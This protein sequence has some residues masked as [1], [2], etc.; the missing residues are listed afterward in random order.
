MNRA[1]GNVSLG[2]ND[3]GHALRRL[4]NEFVVRTAHAL[5]NEAFALEAANDVGAVGEHLCLE[6]IQ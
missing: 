4:V 6:P 5:E 3:D 2:M 1:D